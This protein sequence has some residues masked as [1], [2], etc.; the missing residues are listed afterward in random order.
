ML[1]T[2]GDSSWKEPIPGLE[3]EDAMLCWMMMFLLTPLPEF[4]EVDKQYINIIS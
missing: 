4:Q 3:F 2:F 1:R